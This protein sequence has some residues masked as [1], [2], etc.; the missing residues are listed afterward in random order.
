VK[1]TRK[2]LSWVAS[3]GLISTD[4][5][6]SLWSA[7]EKRNA[8]RPKFDLA[9]VTYYFGAL[10]VIGAMGWFMTEAWERF[11][12]GGIFLLSTIYG[13]CFVLAG[14]T[15]WFKQNLRIPGGLLFTMAVCITPLAIYGLERLT[16]IWPQ[17]APGIYRDYYIWVKGSWLLMELGTI[18]AGLVALKFIRF[19]FLTAPIAFS[20]WY[21]S[22]DLT[23]LLFGKTEFTWD[24]R[25]WV[26]LWFGLAVLLAS[27]LVDRRTKDDYA[28]WGY[29]FGMAAFWGGLSLM[30]SNSEITKFMYCLLNCGLI[31]LAVILQRRIFI[32]FGSIGVFGYLGYLAHRV[33]ENSLLFPF[34][35]SLV[36]ILIIYLG[37]QYQRKR[38]SIEEAI[39]SRIPVSLKRLLPTER[40]QQ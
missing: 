23:P 3:Q 16:G 13:L 8:D 10:I 30:N 19:P 9:N 26:S 38:S 34:A 18:A 31:V 2:D 21:M 14:R 22:M 1:L 39:L 4:Q 20:L 36:G 24:E 28:F 11:G 35:L 37:V 5:A 12:G 29:L 25:L 40:I 6:E 15:L 33:F 27:Y 32:V 7:L 17:G